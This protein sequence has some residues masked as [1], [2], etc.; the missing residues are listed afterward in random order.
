MTLAIDTEQSYLADDI[1]PDA[2]RISCGAY[3]VPTG[4]GLGVTPDLEAIR[5]YEVDGIAGAYLDDAKPGWFPT[6][7]SY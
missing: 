7:P 1:A 5:K 4:P 6:K 3:D 2:P